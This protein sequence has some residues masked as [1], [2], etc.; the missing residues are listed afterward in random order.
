M[1]DPPREHRHRICKLLLA[2][3][4]SA[5]EI[6]LESLILATGGLIDRIARATLRRHHISDPSAVDDAVSLVLDHVRRLPGSGT[7][8]R[9]VSPFVCHD[10][11]EATDPGEAYLAWLTTE[12]SRDVARN[13]HRHARRF[14]PLSSLG[15]VSSGIG[16]R[17]ASMPQSDGT[18]DPQDSTN[19]RIERAI[20][21]LDP[22]LATVLR[23]L[24]DGKPQTV[25]ASSLHVCEGT[26]SRMR[27][28]AIVSVRQF[29][30]DEPDDPD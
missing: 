29:M 19:E 2:W 11:G 27:A 1:L 10:A 3:Q 20:G 8:E 26:V 24:L 18:I 7:T 25:I 28:R 14:Q 4:S 12:R 21:R 5:D 15:P 9:R 13:R 6:D 30:A 17:L 16:R 22:R 23:M